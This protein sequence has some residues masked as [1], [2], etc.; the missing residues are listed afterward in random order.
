MV[1]DVKSES[2]QESD[3]FYSIKHESDESDNEIKSVL[4]GTETMSVTSATSEAPIDGEHY[5]LQF[6]INDEENILAKIKGYRIF[7]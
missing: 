5:D 3:Y 2:S 7:I 1:D 6:N 4:D